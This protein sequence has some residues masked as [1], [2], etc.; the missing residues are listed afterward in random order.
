MENTP[1]IQ[2]VLDD[3]WLNIDVR[4]DEVFNPLN[5]I[6]NN[7]GEDKSYL[8]PGLTF[9]ATRPEYF[10]FTCK[11]ILNVEISP[12]QALLLY[13]IWNRKRPMLIGSR[14]LG[15]AQPLDAKVLAED[16]WKNFGSLKVGDQIFSSNGTLCNV[17][18]IFPQGKK[19]VY[20]I[21]FVDGRSVECSADH[22]WPVDEGLNGTSVLTTLQIIERIENKQYVLIQMNSA[23][24]HLPKQLPEDP[25]KFGQRLLN[26]SVSKKIPDI[27]KFSS[28]EDRLQL[29]RGYF[30]TKLRIEK[31][32]R[33][34]TYVIVKSSY[35]ADGL[36]DIMRSL[37]IRC[38]KV[39]GTKHRPGK[40]INLFNK[41]FI[42]DVEYYITLKTK[43]PITTR[44]DLLDLLEKKYSEI[45]LKRNNQKLSAILQVERLPME[46]EMQCIAVD[47]ID[48][49][50]IT[51]D[52]IVTHNSFILSV[53]SM[54]RALLLPDRKIV[55]VGN[56]FRQ[57]KILLEYCSNIWNNAPVLRD[58]CDSKS[59]PSFAV[60]MGL[61]RIGNSKIIFLPLGDGQKIRGQR[62]NDIIADEFA[63]I[64]LPIFE[65][66]IKGFGAVASDPISKVKYR[67][68]Q[69]E[70][71]RRGVQLKHMEDMSEFYKSNQTI[72]SGTADYDF[73]HFAAYWRRYHQIIDSK[74]DPKKILEIFNGEDQKDA[75]SYTDY[76]IYRIPVELLPEGFMDE[77]VI[78]D[79]KATIHSGIYEM[80]FG[81][82]FSSDSKGFFKRSLIESCVVSDDKP[83]I[84]PSGPVSF[85]PALY[86]N[87]TG[88]YIIG[89]DPASEVDNFSIVVLE[90]H[91]DHRRVV[92]CWTTTRERHKAAFKEG[93][94]DIDD[95]YSY[96]ARKI[97][98]LMKKFNTVQIAMDPQG[99][100]VAVME[101]LHAKNNLQSKEVPI[102]PIIDPEK[103]TDTDDEMGLH[104]VRLC[105]FSSAQWT[106][107]SNHGLRKDMEDKK[108][109][110]PFFDTLALSLSLEED[111]K[112]NRITD[113]LEDCT[114]EIEDLK[115][116]L[117]LIVI[118]VTP[119]GRER[120]DTPGTQ[121]GNKNK[122][123][124]DRYSALLMANDAA[125]RLTMEKMGITYEDDYY[126]SVGFA[127]QSTNLY[128]GNNKSAYSGPGWYDLPIDIYD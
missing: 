59:G 15:K 111:K 10:S 14:G 87:P 7:S 84:L 82:V 39:I 78:A 52:Y 48:N 124:K 120:W 54:L 30:D 85:D 96:C 31:N 98:E 86:G 97:R 101:A 2:R 65:T 3:A 72:V 66:V 105:N 8:L 106:S 74:G 100:G 104:I 49:T 50:Y 18:G 13:D 40:P 37:G 33:K 17:I 95:F 113:T 32:L 90:V 103:P 122:L 46:K 127:S 29:L 94:T 73:K 43:M 83:I 19:Q 76:A 81:S 62:A 20:R 35:L 99:G 88:N 108:L 123:R 4:D 75:F 117:S 16:G 109:I 116:E 91:E 128:D 92:Y 121:T 67:A 28:I 45:R 102:W 64:P 36:V 80:E 22:L 51:N 79:A 6:Y 9:L 112:M 26:K 119:S 89:V 77:G 57:S 68:A 58:L 61:L 12:M 107:E 47:S 5:Y 1:D 114:M 60:D 27:Y 41:Q 63:T 56:A 25:Y 70:A 118:T 42:E 110:F 23:V 93:Y 24:R 125:R 21:T 34:S 126:K 115:R 38:R 53:Y 69:K 44:Q 55:I 71:K 11:Y